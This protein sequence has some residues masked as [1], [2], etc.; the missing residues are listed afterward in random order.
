M[1]GARETNL[2]KHFF[3]RGKRGVVCEAAATR[4]SACCTRPLLF[5]RLPAP[6]APPLAPLPPVFLFAG[7]KKK[8]TR[9]ALILI[10]FPY[11]LPLFNSAWIFLPSPCAA[12]FFFDPGFFWKRA[13][14]GGDARVCAWGCVCW[15]LVFFVRPARHPPLLTAPAR[16]TQRNAFFSYFFFGGG[17]DTRFPKPQPPAL[18]VAVRPGAG[19]GNPVG[20]GVWARLFFTFLHALL[21]TFFSPLPSTTLL[22]TKKRIK[23]QYLARKEIG[24]PRRFGGWVLP[25]ASGRHLARFLSFAHSRLFFVS[26]QVSPPPALVAPRRLQHQPRCFQRPVR[27][28]GRAGGSRIAGPRVPRARFALRPFGFVCASAARP[29]PSHRTLAPTVA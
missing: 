20:V 14:F 15:A 11:L 6:T 22:Q 23:T 4:R 18:S 17:R 9:H 3:S 13:F 7:A 25:A 27:I 1:G 12:P 16:E 8:G 24:G 21:R 5:C 2:S 19:G 26:L 29:Q 10:F 28:G